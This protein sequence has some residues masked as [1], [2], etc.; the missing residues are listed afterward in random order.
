M[1][2]KCEVEPD[3]DCVWVKALGRLPRT[4]WE[5]ERLRLN[6]PVDWQLE[7]L[8][9]WVTFAIG[10]DQVATGTEDEPRYATEILE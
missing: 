6:P 4:P 10:R 9:S 7:G 2:G 3:M 8:A 5:E 1:D